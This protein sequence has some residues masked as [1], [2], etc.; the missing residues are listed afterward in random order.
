MQEAFCYYY[1]AKAGN[2]NYSKVKEL[3]N[4]ALPLYKAVYV[5]GNSDDE[6]NKLEKLVGS[7]K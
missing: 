3:Y 2:G 1:Q 5:N 7:L 6:M 4:Q